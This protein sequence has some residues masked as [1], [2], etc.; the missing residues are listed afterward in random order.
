[1]DNDTVPGGDELS[2]GGRMSLNVSP[3][4]RYARDSHSDFDLV[5]DV[6]PFYDIRMKA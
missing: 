2:L 1:M 5:S 3:R 4:I 6:H